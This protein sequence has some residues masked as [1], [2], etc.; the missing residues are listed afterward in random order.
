VDLVKTLLT[1]LSEACSA[2]LQVF[3]WG[4]HIATL[5]DMFDSLASNVAEPVAP[6]EVLAD[7]ATCLNASPCCSGPGI[8]S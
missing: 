1:K 2:G 4:T 3:D 8:T 7:T 5:E 6:N